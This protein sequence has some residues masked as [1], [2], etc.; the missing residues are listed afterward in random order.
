MPT[1]EP[2]DLPASP[3]MSASETVTTTLPT[4]F[5]ENLPSKKKEEMNQAIITSTSPII[6]STLKPKKMKITLKPT[7][8]TL[9]NSLAT[10]PHTEDPTTIAATT[11]SPQPITT[12]TSAKPETEASK[13]PPKPI[14][15]AFQGIF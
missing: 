9:L 1:I 3:K 13:E 8:S 14:I 2:V 10:S 7:H 5:D 15:S 6:S 4:F 12:T 11:T